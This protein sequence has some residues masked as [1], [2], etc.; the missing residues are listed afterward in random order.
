MPATPTRNTSKEG[1]QDFKRKISK[2]GVQLDST[3][4]GIIES[5]SEYRLRRRKSTDIKG[6]D[7]STNISKRRI[8]SRSR[9]IRNTRGANSKDASSRYE[10]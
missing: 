1:T 3:A 10:L 7:S 4:H 2:R 8:D 9:D 5:L 6:A